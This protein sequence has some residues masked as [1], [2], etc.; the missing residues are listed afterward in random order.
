MGDLIP[1]TQHGVE[2][3]PPPSA[4]GALVVASGDTLYELARRYGVPVRDLIDANGLKPPYVL[5]VGQRLTLPS[6]RYHTVSRG[7]TL[8]SVSRMYQVDM[9][10]LARAN[11]L[12]APFS[13]RL[14][15]RLKLPGA[16]ASE[17]Q[18]QVASAAPVVSA[19]APARP[20][21]P[22]ARPPRA[23]TT[24]MPAGPAASSP[25]IAPRMEASPTPT[26]AEASPMQAQ[27]KPQS[28]P[29]ALPP[30]AA[31]PASVARVEPAPPASSVTRQTAATVPPAAEPPARSAARFAWPVRGSIVSDFGPK[32]GGLH[33]DGINIGA[34]HGTTVVA[35]E[36]GVVAYAG[37]E[38][39]GF[40]NLLLIRHSDGW[41]SAYAHLDE[42][43]VARGAKVKRGQRIGSVGS[44]GAVTSPQLH[45]E[46][47][48]GSRA[49]DPREHLG[50]RSVS[51]AD[52]SD[53]PPSPG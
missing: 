21:L 53:G 38:L 33:N 40:G 23:A 1:V 45:F 46:L 5:Q 19:G 16:D 51:Q 30:P 25:A 44:T 26:A 28:E 36:N 49:V 7:D 52:A 22:A 37:N 34:P 11:E 24:S 10:E 42:I 3:P 31:K 47:R 14:G 39:K 13:V 48:R 9:A 8:Y 43:K 15:Q 17:V 27:S 29:P 35:A 18:V 32:A 20:P 50:P 41:V 6:A 4:G 12:K 2:A